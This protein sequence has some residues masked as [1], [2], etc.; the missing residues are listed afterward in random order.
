MLTKFI[1]L[2]PVLCSNI[3]AGTP[4]SELQF[5]TAVDDYRHALLDQSGTSLNPIL[6]SIHP[7]PN[8]RDFD[9][10][11]K[12]ALSKKGAFENWEGKLSLSVLRRTVLLTFTPSCSAQ[13]LMRNA[14]DSGHLDL[15]DLATVIRIPST[16]S[17]ILER[18]KPFGQ[19]ALVSGKLFL[20][21]AAS[22]VLSTVLTR[23]ATQDSGPFRM[24]N[25]PAGAG[26]RSPIYLTQ[27]QSI[28]LLQ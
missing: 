14:S 27:F 8:P 2:L 24:P 16:L 22:R 23:T 13:I 19:T 4:D 21:P 10:T 5:C 25:S 3:V 17:D 26:V 1:V 18:A 11:A 9:H 12:T 15:N 20:I 28:R 6:R 7:P